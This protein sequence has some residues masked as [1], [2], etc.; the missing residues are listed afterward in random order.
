M[1]LSQVLDK[2]RD[3]G[4]VFW[5]RD[6]DFHP[7]KNKH[8]ARLFLSTPSGYAWELVVTGHK[9]FDVRAGKG[10]GGSIDLVK[11]LLGI[12]FV[13]AVKLLSSSTSPT[14]GPAPN[15]YCR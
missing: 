3:A 8:T 13:M 1:P 11:H 7:E 12:D 6:P 14:R 4:K 2:L 15:L 9:W 5:R 10:G